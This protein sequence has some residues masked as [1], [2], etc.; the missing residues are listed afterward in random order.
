MESTYVT[1]FINKKVCPSVKGYS[2]F[3]KLPLVAA[4]TFITPVPWVL[5]GILFVI[6]FYLMP[7]NPN[8]NSTKETK[9]KDGTKSLLVAFI[10]VFVLMF[11]IALFA[12]LLIC[13]LNGI[14]VKENNGVFDNLISM[15]KQANL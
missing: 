14:K 10:A 13:E 15:L 12:K 8:I 9:K 7:L 2:G 5:I 6:F 4:A 3:L 1:N 11:T